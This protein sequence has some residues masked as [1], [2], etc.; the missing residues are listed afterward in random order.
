MEDNNSDEPPTKLLIMNSSD[1]LESAELASASVSI[2]ST[3]DGNHSLNAINVD[4]RPPPPL[5]AAARNRGQSLLKNNVISTHG[6]SE[7]SGSVFTT[8]AEESKRT[9]WKCK[10]CN[11]RHSNKETVSLH[12]KSHSESEQRQVDE[13]VRA[14]ECFVYNVP[15]AFTLFRSVCS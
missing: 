13:R 7:T 4:L 14:F 8:I 12:V 1:Y 2:V 9:M 11:F 15:A 10:R 3:S 5:K 6:Q